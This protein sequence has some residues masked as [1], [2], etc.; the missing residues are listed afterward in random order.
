MNVGAWGRGDSNLLKLVSPPRGKD[1]ES[2]RAGRVG[3]TV[4]GN[5]LLLM[6]QLV[7]P[8]ILI[9]KSVGRCRVPFSTLVT[10]KEHRA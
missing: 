9:L 3:L 2:S 10:E 5:L 4:H 8:I 6:A 7:Q 1:S